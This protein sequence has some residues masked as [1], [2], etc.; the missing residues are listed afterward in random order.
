[1]PYIPQEILDKIIGY[2]TADEPEVGLKFSNF[3]S[4]VSHNFH[5]I[6]LPYKFRSLT[7]RFDHSGFKRKNTRSGTTTPQPNPIPSFCQAINAG[8]A[9][10]LSLVPL[11]QELSLLYWTGRDIFGNLRTPEPFEN[12]ING[13]LSFRNL[14]KLTM[15]KCFTTPV[16]M[17]QLG[18]L[19]QLRSLHTWYCHDLYKEYGDT[20]SRLEAYGALSN[21]QFL[22]TLDCQKDGT[23][24]KRQLACIPMKILRI[25]K[26]S[27]FEVIKAFLKTDPPVQLKE[28]WLTCFYWGD[29]SMLW[30]YLSRVTSLTHLS[31]PYF[32]SNPSDV[33]PSFI[34]SIPELQYLHIH[35]ALAPRFADQP[36]KEMEIETKSKPGQ[37]M[38]EVRQHWQGTVFP[39]VEHLKTNRPYDELDEIPI[40]FWREFLLN[41]SKVR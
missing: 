28:L 15:K 23:Q 41:V 26:S 29:H 1:M 5:Q 16:I 11:V 27:D 38:V 6:I 37:L 13:I 7:F 3:A 22:H 36:M 4:F 17:E 40:E 24:F 33:P 9:H 25:L 35:I 20:S 34:F 8:D 12:F 30:N 2:A 18:K 10:A 31:L 39:H 21:L 32:H 19:V 14:T